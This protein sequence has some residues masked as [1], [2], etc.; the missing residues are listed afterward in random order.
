[1]IIYSAV[2]ETKNEDRDKG[3]TM[4]DEDWVRNRV[5]DSGAG[6]Q[7]VKADTDEPSA[8]PATKKAKTMENASEAPEEAQKCGEAEGNCG[9]E[10]TGDGKVVGIDDEGKSEVEDVDRAAEGGETSERLAGMVFAITGLTPLPLTPHRHP[11]D[12]PVCPQEN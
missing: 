2:S 9:D 5:M 1:V 12:Q 7:K 6:R 4:V 10:N 11:I 8:P 3:V